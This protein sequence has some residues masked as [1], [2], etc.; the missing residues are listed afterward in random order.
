M[1]TKLINFTEDHLNTKVLFDYTDEDFDRATFVGYD[2]ICAIGRRLYCQ[3][4]ISKAWEKA[5][6]YKKL[7]HLE[8]TQDDVEYLHQ[9]AMEYSIKL[10]DATTYEEKVEYFKDFMTY[11]ELWKANRKGEKQ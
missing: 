2:V 10:R 8:V 3:T 9:K 1:I 4:P 7:E 11:M 5:V 6:A